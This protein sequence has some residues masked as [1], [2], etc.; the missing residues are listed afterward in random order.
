ML[1]EI[2]HL[3]DNLS[4]TGNDF[5]N[6]LSTGDFTLNSKYWG[7]YDGKTYKSIPHSGAQDVRSVV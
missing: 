5:T 1:H 3:V 2:G 6:Q 7:G 4:D